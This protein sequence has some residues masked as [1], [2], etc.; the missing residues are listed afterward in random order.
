[1]AGKGPTFINEENMKYAGRH[2]LRSGDPVEPAEYRPVTVP[3]TGGTYLTKAA[4]AD[5]D[6][7]PLATLEPYRSIVTRRSPGEAVRRRSTS[8]WGIT[9]SSGGGAAAATR[10]LEHVPLGN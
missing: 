5:L 3:L 10:I 1:M 7:F 9:T 6:S 2:F 8:S 4:W